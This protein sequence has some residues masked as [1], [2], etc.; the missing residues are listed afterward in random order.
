MVGIVLMVDIA[1]LEVSIVV[2]DLVEEQYW[3]KC[4]VKGY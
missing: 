3:P 1:K 2:G 4:L